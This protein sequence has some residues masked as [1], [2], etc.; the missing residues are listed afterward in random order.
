MWH[1]LKRWRDWAMHDLWPMQRLGVRPQ[2]LHCSY[3]KAGLTVHDQPI[4]W[5]AEAVLV[6]ALVRLPAGRSPADFQLRIGKDPPIAAETI[7]RDEADDRHHLF[8]RLTPPTESTTAELLWRTT[9]LGQLS[10][11]VLTREDF[12]AGLKI[13]IPA[14]FVR[15]GDQS[16]AC[17]TFVSSQ[18]RGLLASAVITSPTSL[19]PLRDLGLQV[20]FRADRKGGPAFV[21]GAPLTS[22]QLAGK[23]ALVS[24]IPPKFPRRVGLWSVTWM[25]GNRP[26]FAQR[27]RAIS[28]AHFQRSLRICDTRFLIQSAKHGMSLLRQVPPLDKED[29]VGPCFLVAS[30][31]AGMAGI[32]TLHIHA[33]VNGAETM[34]VLSEQEVLVTDGPTLVVPGTVDIHDLAEVRG[35][36]VRVKDTVLGSISLTPAP[37][38]DFNSEGGFK[39]VDDF[40]WTAAA[41]EELSKRLGGLMGNP[42][43]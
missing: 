8:F 18:C 7:R 10:L 20:E 13:Q 36:E 9:S 15:L 42:K 5:N 19:A 39:P 4:P 37:A 31:E 1:W 25:V 2:A 35:F 28:Q 30:G 23:Q 29:R 11:P 32:C 12:I 6:E 24:L 17:Q 14:L 3:E 34:P 41:E 33:Q 43:P 26:L 40:I 27:F 38:A 22:S 21:V 16:V